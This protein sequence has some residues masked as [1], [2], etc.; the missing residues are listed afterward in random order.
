MLVSNHY[1]TSSTELEYSGSKFSV[2]NFYEEV[3]KVSQ[4]H[5]KNCLIYTVNNKPYIVG[6]YARFNRYHSYLRGETKEFLKKYGWF[7]QLENIYE[8]VIARIA[9]VYDA[10]HRILELI[11]SLE[12]STGFTSHYVEIKPVKDWGYCYYAIEAPRGI[13]YQR[14]NLDESGRV[15]SA[16]IV[17]PTAQN[18]ALA[19]DITRKS[20]HGLTVEKAIKLAKKIVVSLDPCISCSVHS[21]NVR[22]VHYLEEKQ[23]K[24]REGTSYDPRLS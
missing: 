24:T 5:G 8:S 18:I 7:K 14:F 2:D 13:L 23:A 16:N 4:K 1:P 9:E 21:L 6:P 20:V 19:E 17:T 11:S 22:I 3:V 10:L 12:S 15:V